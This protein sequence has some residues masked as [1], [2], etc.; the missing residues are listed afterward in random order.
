MR[1]LRDVSLDLY[2]VA[3]RYGLVVETRANDICGNRLFSDSYV[4]VC[5]L[6]HPLNIY[7]IH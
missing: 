1:M 6:A 5:A 3:G 2:I 4:S 7:N